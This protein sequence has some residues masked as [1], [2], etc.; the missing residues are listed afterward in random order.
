MKAYFISL[1]VLDSC[2]HIS[3]TSTKATKLQFCIKFVVLVTIHYLNATIFINAVHLRTLSPQ[4]QNFPRYYSHA[5]CNELVIL[6][7]NNGYYI[8]ES[9]ITA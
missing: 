3:L 4:L 9:T 2:N 7:L 5:Q 6:N 1:Y 8:L